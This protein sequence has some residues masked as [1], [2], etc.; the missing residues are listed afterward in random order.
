MGK[1]QVQRAESFATMTLFTLKIHSKNVISLTMFR[2]S[3]VVIEYTKVINSRST[4]VR[5]T[6]P[7]VVPVQTNNLV[8]K[9]TRRVLQ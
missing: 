4:T 9:I 2:C 3:N 1:Y 5:P 7:E 8:K 6:C